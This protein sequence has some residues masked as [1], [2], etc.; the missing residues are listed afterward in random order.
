MIKKT[1]N[2]AITVTPVILCGGS[3]T[4]LWP[5]SRLGFPKQFLCLTSQESLFQQAATRLTQLASADIDVSPLLVVTGEDHRFLVVEQLREVGITLCQALLEPEGR[6]TAP[7]LTMAALAADVKT[8]DPVLVV[9]PADQTVVN[10]AEFTHVMR[11]AILEANSGS[12]V[13]MGITPDRPE[14]GYGYIQAKGLDAVRM[15]QRFVEKPDAVTAQSYLD[16]GGYFWNAG[17]FVLKASVWIQ[18]LKQFRPDILRAS[19][20][21]WSQRRE[22]GNFIRLPE[23]AFKAVPSES[24]DY[25]VME[26]ASDS[27]LQ[28]K[29]I[30]FEGGW[31]DLGTWEAVWNVLSKDTM[32][33]AH[34]GDVM[35]TDSRNSLVHA[36]SRLVSL[37]GV[38]DLIVV[39]TPDAVLVAERSCSQDVK[40]IVKA[41][42]D[43]GREEHELHR[44]VHRPWGWYENIGEG[45]RYKVKRIQVKP[46][47][48]ISLQKHHRRAEHWVV[49][50]GMAEVTCGKEKF[51]L[52]ENQSAYI[53][54]DEVHRLANPGSIPLLIIEVQ[55]GDY[56]GED[57]IVRLEDS[58]GRADNERA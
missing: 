12:F 21:A 56:L 28:V 23:E 25:A 9:S 19:N 24:I 43:Q 31:S 40:Q 1:I 5:L 35:L 16:S 51:L 2:S 22:D 49:V 36:T 45:G 10:T 13:V 4:R 15:V 48:S 42:S 39:E 33:N 6:N 44:K 20:T 46:G 11:R 29:M 41:L 52:Y 3:G 50:A 38:K 30:P 55:T 54:L 27:D 26:H 57:D 53:P 7:A 18:A 58:Y 34:A 37:V 8:R 17:I 14:T 47:A 32:G